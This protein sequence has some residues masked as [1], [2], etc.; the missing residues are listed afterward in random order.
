MTMRKVAALSLLLLS[1][2]LVD[3]EVDVPETC[4]ERKNV[5]IPATENGLPPMDFDLGAEELSELPLDQALL[6]VLRVELASDEDLS[7]LDSVSLSLDGE[8]LVAC[9]AQGCAGG[10]VIDLGDRAAI[11]L[12]LAV[13][14]ELPSHEW[15]A[16]VKVCFEAKTGFSI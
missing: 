6:T 5:V 1:G 10:G 8:E 9:D 12:Q 2:C 3:V 13:E 14:G 16:D 4:V 15:T 11:T 7:N